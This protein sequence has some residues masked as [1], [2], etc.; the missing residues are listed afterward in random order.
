VIHGQVLDVT[1]FLDVRLESLSSQLANCKLNNET[2]SHPGGASIILKYA[3]DDATRA[4]DEVHKPETLTRNL[5]TDCFLGTL[6]PANAFAT[7]SNKTAEGLRLEEERKR[8]PPL[9]RL[10]TLDDFE[11]GFLCLDKMAI[12]IPYL[13]LFFR[14]WPGK[15]CQGTL[16]DFGHRELMTNVVSLIPT[17]QPSSF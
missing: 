6:D 17:L 12:A 14:L 3:G 16:L 11:V 8:L 10:L 4:F 15:S 13:L 5:S 9:D 7:H 2:Q 1:G